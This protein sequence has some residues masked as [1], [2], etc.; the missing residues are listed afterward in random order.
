[1]A[2]CAINTTNDMPIVL[3]ESLKSLGLVDFHI[4]PHYLDTDPDSTHKG[5]S[6]RF[7][8][9]DILTRSKT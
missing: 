8:L 9:Q 3:P 2:T 6:L 7:Y 1:M 4:N 5:V